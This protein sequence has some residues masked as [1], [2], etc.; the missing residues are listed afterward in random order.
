VLVF[1]GSDF[2]ARCR[3]LCNSLRTSSVVAIFCAIDGLEV[4]VNQG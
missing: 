1:A 4:G 2:P 3:R